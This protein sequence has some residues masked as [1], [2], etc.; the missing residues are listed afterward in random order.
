[1]SEH[2]AEARREWQ[3]AIVKAVHPDTWEV[4]VEPVHTTS[5]IIRR[6][7]IY[8]HFLPEVHGIGP[9]EKT[10]MPERQS[11]VLVGWLDAYSQSPVAIPLH[12]LVAGVEALANLVYVSEHLHFRISINREGVLEIRN[13][14][15]GAPL[16]QIRILEQGGVVRIDTPKTRVVLKDSDGSVTIECDGD[17]KVEAGGNADVTAGGDV[18]VTGTNVN[19]TGATI[20]LN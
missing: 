4:D 2:P 13:A 7:K 18:N 10:A 11:K 3:L 14:K 6:A 8:S 12:H 19:V 1:M 5:G 9:D 20:N 17:L 15:E 16:L